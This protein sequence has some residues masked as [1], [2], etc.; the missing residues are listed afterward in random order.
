MKSKILIALF[1]ILPCGG[2]GDSSSEKSLFTYLTPASQKNS[3]DSHLAL[4]GIYFDQSE[5][6][7]ALEHSLQAVKQ[8]PLSEKAAVI[9]GFSYLGVSGVS[10]LSLIQLLSQKKTSSETDK[11]TSSTDSLS[12]ISAISLNQN[13]FAALAKSID[14]EDPALPVIIPKCADD[15]RKAVE[16]LSFLNEAIKAICPFVH[17]QV[18]ISTDARHVCF[19]TK[20]LRT[21][22]A[23][24]HLLWAFT[25]LIEAMAFHSVI[26][27][28]TTESQKT[29]LELRV[30]S[31]QKD[32]VINVDQLPAFIRKL[33]SLTALI[34]Q[35]IPIS[36]ECSAA[37]PQTQLSALINDLLSAGSGFA[38]IPGV[39]ASLTQG[40]NE[41]VKNLN[42]IQQS[43][44]SVGAEKQKSQSLKKDF[45]KKMSEVIA[46]KINEIKPENIT[47]EQADSVCLSYKTISA[48][49]V[50]A[51]ETPDLC[52]GIGGFLD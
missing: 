2:C 48:G 43:T 46:A 44:S 50:S 5:F 31:I 13:E 34:D 40:I 49:S 23:H 21:Q 20:G 18:K 32:N 39:P 52:K 28:K 24:A 25:H 36:G 51:E 29:N 15:A 41:I 16:K 3:F 6:Q 26:T 4:A 42:Q 10:P 38:S 33:D 1:C 12:S 11:K 7:K 37:A 27:Y 19:A 30:D 17:D 45:T 47:K 35:V 9:L 8:N 22:T 14:R